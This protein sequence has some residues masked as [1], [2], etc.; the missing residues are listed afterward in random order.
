MRRVPPT[1]ARAG[2]PRTVAALARDL[3]AL[4]VR[5][6]DLLHVHA[7]LR[8]IGP[9]EGGAD[10]VLDALR[11]AL[12][13]TGTMV[14]TFGAENPFDWVNERPEPE[15]PALLAG[16]PAFDARRDR[17]EGDVGVLAELFRT[18][19]G[20]EVSD[21]PEGRFGASGP[22]AAALLA[23]QPWDDYYGPGS[24][25][26]RFTDAGGRVL[27][28]GADLD[29]VT[30]LH[31]AEYLAPVAGKRR[32]RRSRVVRRAD[33]ATEVRVVEG[34]D[35]TGGI[36]EQEGEDYFARILR[37]YLA[38][39]RA[40]AAGRVGGATSELL[41]AADLVAFGAAWM[42]EHLRRA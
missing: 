37:A 35:D 16:A 39:G 8:R 25:L 38:T 18:R 30:V 9:V 13:P 41:D 29:T 12:G 5:D 10:G 33:G 17:V 2:R 36:V 22:L 27:R 34:L 23:D 15:R 31:W 28:L 1:P 21:H 3:R 20:T 26:Q 32:V 24:P 4:G 40:S 19:P 7:S 6:G 42:G 11:G 14:M